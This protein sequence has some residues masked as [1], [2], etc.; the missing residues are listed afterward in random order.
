MDL[1]NVYDNSAPGRPPVLILESRLGEVLFVADD[2]PPW[3]LAA[4]V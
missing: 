4:L 1:I 2:A 3:L